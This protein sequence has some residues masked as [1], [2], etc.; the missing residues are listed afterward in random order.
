MSTKALITGCTGQA[1]LYLAEFL[2]ERDYEVFGLVRGQNNPK[3]AKVLE[4]T[5]TIKLIE[6]DLRDLSSLVS[7]LNQAQPQE[8]YNLGAMSFVGM[9]W[10]QPILTAEV[11]GLGVLNMLE[12]IRIHTRGA[13]SIRFFQS[14]SSEMFGRVRETPQNEM[15][16]FNPRSP[17]G[18]AKTFGH[19]A[20]VN[21][22]ESYD[23]FACSGIMF[24]FES[25]RR[26]LEF[27]TR[28]I[29]R[30]AAMISKGL[31]D[32]VDLG[33]LGVKR[34]WGFAKE[35]VEGMWR[36]LQADN[37]ED[38]V[39]A[40]NETHTVKELIELTCEK[41]GFD[42]EWKG[43][44]VDEKGFDK[45]GFYVENPFWP[46]YLIVIVPYVKKLHR[47]KLSKTM[48]EYL[49]NIYMPAYNA[50]FSVSAAS[51]G[52]AFVPWINGDIDKILCEQYERTVRKDNC[53]SFEGL[54]LQIPKDNYR[55]HYN[56]VKVRVHRYVNGQ[57][58]IFHGPRKLAEYDNKGQ[59]K[60][61]LSKKAA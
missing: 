48:Q 56:K 13:T 2:A 18:V 44:G 32:H 61:L 59:L 33:S 47:E 14:S 5:P 3:I 21:Y 8:V 27:V 37:P 43:S 11:T 6:G 20:T 60:D 42:I 7:A 31:T 46:R 23:M 9:S 26:G 34:D 30:A 55:C 50:E 52:T 22:R 53:V 51:E 40:T 28:K 4:I 19:Y 49:K 16:P 45:N 36:I 54:I 25:E 39:L 35:Y 41:L 24:N 15:T 10:K 1:G 17:Y 29:T 12:A 58:A 57:L 38:F